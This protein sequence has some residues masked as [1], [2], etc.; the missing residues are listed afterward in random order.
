MT[1]VRHKKLK[2]GKI[3]AYEVSSYWDSKKKQP[4]AT[5]KY[6][7][8]VDKSGNLIP[9]KDLLKKKRLKLEG[10]EKL[11]LD[12][13]NAYLCYNFIKKSYIYECFDFLRENEELIILM[14]YKLCQ[15]GPM[16]NAEIWLENSFLKLKTE[17]SKISS[18]SISKILSFIGEEKIQQDFFKKYIKKINATASECVI[19]DAKSLPNQINS[20]YNAWGYSDGGI[21]SQFRFHCVVD[22]LTK[23]PIY[24]RLVPGNI[25]DVSALKCTIDELKALGLKQS[26]A[27]LDAGYCSEHNIKELRKN[28]IDFLMRLPCGRN[29]YKDLIKEYSGALE[30]LSNAVQF[31]KRSL[32]VKKI[33]CNIYENKGFAYLVLDPARKT[34]DLEELILKRHERKL[35]TKQEDTNIEEINKQEQY[36]FAK[37]GMFI[38]ISSKEINIESVL[39][40]YYTR[41]TI[42]QIFGFAKNDLDLLPIRCHSDNN[43]RGYLFFQFLILIIFIEMREILKTKY[44]VEQALMITRG[45]KCKIYK[46][47]Y[48]IQEASKKQNEIF[49]LL[50]DIVPSEG[51]I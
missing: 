48:I 36:A 32:F 21:E 35:E 18:Q 38:L 7:G 1:F 33:E 30:N 46:D 24:Y 41:Q 51:G 9:K 8:T 29:L 15:S 43:I 4:R 2:S 11:I 12:F 47:I 25:A 10:Q 44:T 5:S 40:T 28:E 27:L 45:L 26:F 19:I 3:Y 50:K 13:G 20:D 39:Y 34:K 37:A 14:A 6:I 42:E 49:N 23:K 16:Y 31:G 17:P 22:Q